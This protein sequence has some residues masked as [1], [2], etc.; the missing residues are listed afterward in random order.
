VRSHDLP[1]DRDHPD[2]LEDS[3]V[4]AQSYALRKMP[5]DSV[6]T[7]RGCTRL[8]KKCLVHRVERVLRGGGVRIFQIGLG[9]APPTPLG[10]GSDSI[11]TSERGGVGA[12]FCSAADLPLHPACHFVAGGGRAAI[13]AALLTLKRSARARST[14]Q[15]PVPT[16][17]PIQSP[18]AR[19]CRRQTCIR[20]RSRLQM[21]TL[22]IYAR[23]LPEACARL[24]GVVCSGAGGSCAPLPIAT[25]RPV[26]L[27]AH[28]T[29]RTA[30]ERACAT[31][32]Y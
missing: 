17:V 5:F 9:V 23:L 26:A 32:E 2:R 12:S 21:C 29:P 7:R 13:F 8:S 3:P 28:P 30:Q 14:R 15:S 27:G 19:K 25:R 11:A 18:R 31:S 6:L 1:V 10:K 4:I 16:Y 22:P 24:C 20:E